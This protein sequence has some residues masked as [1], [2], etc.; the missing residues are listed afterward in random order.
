[1]ES[2]KQ[3]SSFIKRI[4][5][6]PLNIRIRL[7]SS[8]NPKIIK[9]IAEIILNIIHKN[10]EV[11]RSALSQ[12]RKFKKVLYRLVAAKDDTS[13][14]KILLGNPKCLVPLGVIFKK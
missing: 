12:F 6:A 8:S 10:I 5:T 13:R 9:T 2:V 14:K 11:P 7:L 4:V 3:Y 1:M